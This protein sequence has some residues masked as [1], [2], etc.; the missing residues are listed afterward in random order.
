MTPN[1]RP[2][3]NLPTEILHTKTRL[4]RLELQER[5]RALKLCLVSGSIK[6]ESENGL[7]DISVDVCIVG[8]FVLLPLVRYNELAKTA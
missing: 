7:V 6:N 4:L 2:E 3:S 1:P 8:D 5:S